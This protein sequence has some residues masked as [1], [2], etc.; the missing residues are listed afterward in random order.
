[1]D[2]RA[3]RLISLW[4]QLF[5]WE[6]QVRQQVRIQSQTL[7]LTKSGSATFNPRYDKGTRQRDT[8][9]P[10]SPFALPPGIV[11][12]SHPV[13]LL[14]AVGQAGMYRDAALLDWHTV[15]E[16]AQMSD[17]PKELPATMS[18]SDWWSDLGKKTHSCKTN[19]NLQR[20]QNTRRTFL[21]CCNTDP[22]LDCSCWKY[23]TS[24]SSGSLLVMHNKSKHSL[25]SS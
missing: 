15:I 5:S 3:S 6:E 24:G 18:K 20:I 23:I 4:G 10:S 11:D 14:V 8:S 17:S 25:S 16:E 7:L 22:A 12:S 13:Q 1:M 9:V 19:C 2:S 21:P